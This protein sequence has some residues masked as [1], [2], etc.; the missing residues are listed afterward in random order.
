MI[1]PVAL[2]D[3][4][5]DF[6][7]HARRPGRRV[8]VIAARPLRPRHEPARD[9][10]HVAQGRGGGQSQGRHAR[11]QDPRPAR[12]S[13]SAT[14]R[15]GDSITG[16]AA[17]DG[18][19]SLSLPISTGANKLRISATDPAGNV[20]ELVLTVSRGSGKLRASLCAS[21]YSI[22]LRDLPATIRLTVIVDD[23]DG[24]PA[25]GCRGDLHAEHPGDPHDDRHGDDRC[26]RRRPVRDEGPVRGQD[27]RWQRRGPRPHRANSAARPTTPRSRSRNSR[28]DSARARSYHPTDADVALSALRDSPGR[29]GP[30]LGLPALLHRLRHVPPFPA[31][32]RGEDR[33]LRPR[34]ASSAARRRRDP[35]VLGRLAGGVDPR[36]GG[37]PTIAPAASDGTATRRIEFVEIE[38]VVGSD[39]VMS[40]PAGVRPTLGPATEPRWSLW[41]DPDH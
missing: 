1:I 36:P 31:V 12:R 21:S 28:I 3:G 8:R 33:V 25:R 19:F 6:T 16:T 2:T 23:P 41:G 5:N 13:S 18:T 15:T 14:R 7:R 40:G 37:L 30:V 32:G 10:A 17:A 4:I 9:H 39:E 24:G 29:D 35:V 34:S 26:Q 11:G 20:N 38:D 22:R 27:R